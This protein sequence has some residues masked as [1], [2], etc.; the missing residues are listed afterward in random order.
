MLQVKKKT[1][2]LYNPQRQTK[3]DLIENFVVRLDVFNNIFNQIKKDKMNHPPQHYIIQGQRGSGKTTLLRRLFF[4][5]QD[6]P[7]LNK[8]L[9]PVIFNEEQYHIRTL[10]RFWE[11]IAGELENSNPESF[12]GISVKLELLTDNNYEQACIDL[13]NDYLK[14]NKHKII[15]FLDN[16]GVMYSKFNKKERQRLREVLLTNPN[17]RLIGASAIVLEFNYDYSDPFFEFFKVVQLQGLNSKETIELLLQLD[18]YYGSKNISAIVKTNPARIET[19]R[20]LTSGMPRTIVI[21]FDIFID[22]QDGDAY[23]DLESVLDQVTPLYKHRMD[24]LSPQQQEIVDCIALNWDAIE[25]KEIVKKT[26]IPSKVVSAQLKQLEKFQ[27]IEK[28]ATSKKNYFYRIHERFFNIWYLMRNGR[29]KERKRV[30]YLVRFLESW[31]N[32]EELE[33]RA[34]QHLKALKSGQLYPPFALHF[35]EALAATKIPIEQQ[36]ELIKETRKFLKKE[37]PELANSLSQSDIEIIEKVECLIDK[38]SFQKALIILENVH[39]NKNWV[40]FLKG[41][42]FNYLKDFDKA[43]K[44]YELAIKIGFKD[45]LNNLAVLYEIKLKNVEQAQK[46]YHKAI[47]NGDVDALNNLALLCQISLKDIEQAQKYFYM[48]VKTG[49][50][51][52]MYNLAHLY[53]TEL[54]DIEKARNYYQLAVDAGHTRAM[55]SLAQLYEAELKNIDHAKKYYQMATK[56]GHAVAKYKLAG[57]L[58]LQKQEKKRALSL[59]L[60]VVSTHDMSI[61]LIEKLVLLWNNENEKAI[62]G[63]IDLFKK[64]SKVKTDLQKNQLILLMLLAK[65]QYNFT[66]KLFESPDLNLKEI[67]KP[68]Y[69]ALMYF[70]QDRFPDEYKRMGG[71]LKETVE[72]V[73]AAVKQMAIDYK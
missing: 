49:H 48:A 68:V 17:I 70:M 57:I 65:K 72:E 39:E 66:L 8:W 35:S 63:L 13:I 21:L 61:V 36:D 6:E 50:V 38:N 7:K 54:K 34:Q 14:K 45:A 22:T 26:R 53:E 73:I 46:Y 32:R 56:A 25:V 5:V 2:L 42:I 41:H 11:N 10:E 29:R 43:A 15:I 9:I 71:E 16:F 58:L 60:D 33:R 64:I 19:L 12:N 44:Q 27:V 24:D 37:A 1:P 4:A 18:S 30:L 52:A 23:H 59:V 69:Y 67:H 55:Y 3:A 51:A 31:C 62:Y 40:P 20:R 47:K 28:E